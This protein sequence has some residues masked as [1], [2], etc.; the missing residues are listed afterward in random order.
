MK[1]LIAEDDNASRLRLEKLLSD[2]GHQVTACGAQAWERYLAGRFHLI[3]SGQTD[4]PDFC[5]KIRAV[6]DRHCYF[7]LLSSRRSDFSRQI[8]SGIDVLLTKPPDKDELKRHLKIV[9]SLVALRSGEC[10]LLPLCAWCQRTRLGDDL[11]LHLD[12]GDA[13]FTYSICPHCS[14]NLRSM[15]KSNSNP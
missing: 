7:I 6:S 8:D 9:E 3:I 14:G 10:R 5:R 12:T 11:W 2:W 15:S 4:G 13:D 1:V